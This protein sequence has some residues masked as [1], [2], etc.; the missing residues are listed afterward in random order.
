MSGAENTSDERLI[1]GTCFI[2][3][4]HFIVIIVMSAKHSF[5]SLYSVKW[6]NLELSSMNG[7]MVI[8]T[9]C[10]GFNNYDLGMFK[11]FAGYFW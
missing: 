8:D 1:R 11:L 5:I 7:G 4:I 2:N 6:L 3:D 9:P 10:Y